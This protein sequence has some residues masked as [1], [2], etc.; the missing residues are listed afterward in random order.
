MFGAIADR[1]QERSFS[2]YL[3]SSA[4]VT[5]LCVCH[6]FVRLLLLR[7]PTRST[8]ET[9]HDKS[10]SSSNRVARALYTRTCFQ[11]YRGHMVCYSCCTFASLPC[12]VTGRSRQDATTAE[13][14]PRLHSAARTGRA[15]PPWH[16]VVSSLLILRWSL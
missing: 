7:V 13:H 10:V 12:R 1:R 11:I 15:L 16:P 4:V 9:W 8:S 14:A 2:N 5:C 6:V 3:R